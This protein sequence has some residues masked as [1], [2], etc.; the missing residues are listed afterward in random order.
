MV[1]EVNHRGNDA[2]TAGLTHANQGEGLV[3]K[4]NPELP[5]ESCFATVSDEAQKVEQVV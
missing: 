1:A 3:L 4:A 2:V 5:P